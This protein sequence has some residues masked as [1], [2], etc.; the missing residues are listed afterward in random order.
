MYVLAFIQKK[1]AILFFYNYT[2]TMHTQLHFKLKTFEKLLVA[3][4]YSK[5]CWISSAHE[6]KYIYEVQILSRELFR[7][8]HPLSSTI[9]LH[10]REGRR[11]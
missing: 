4:I 6:T 3:L 7:K 5:F 9:S 1:K 8:I 10:Q 2:V 11:M